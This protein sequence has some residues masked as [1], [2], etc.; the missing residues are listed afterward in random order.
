MDASSAR[1]PKPVKLDATGR[2]APELYVQLLILLITGE[3]PME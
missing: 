1:E 2:K 3:M